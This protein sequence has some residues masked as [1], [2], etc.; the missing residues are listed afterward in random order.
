MAADYHGPYIIG[1]IDGV[2]SGVREVGILEY[3]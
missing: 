3:Y 2:A 1:W